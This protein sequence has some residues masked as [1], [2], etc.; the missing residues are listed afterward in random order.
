[1]ETLAQETV[2]LEPISFQ[3]FPPSTE[4]LCSRP[5]PFATPLLR[6]I[7]VSATPAFIE[8]PLEPP[9]A[10][11]SKYTQSPR[12]PETG[13][14]ARF[15]INT[16]TATLLPLLSMLILNLPIVPPWPVPLFLQPLVAWVAVTAMTGQSIV[17]V[18]RVASD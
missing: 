15:C 7:C 10:P 1:M 12:F 2:I 3:V 16:V 6:L 9:V 5:V 18:D 14:V 13:F 11:V 8:V 17:I 4:Y